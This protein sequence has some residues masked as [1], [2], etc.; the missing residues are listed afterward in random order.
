MC[1]QGGQRD[2]KLLRSSFDCCVWVSAK[3]CG[4]SC[5]T[6]SGYRLS[7][8][9]F[10]NKDFLVTIRRKIDSRIDALAVLWPLKQIIRMKINSQ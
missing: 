3:A 2:R 9:T 1:V 7:N 4:A 5:S 10:Q 6:S 8:L